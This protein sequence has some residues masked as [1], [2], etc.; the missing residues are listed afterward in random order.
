MRMQSGHWPWEEDTAQ[1]RN[2]F[3]SPIRLRRSATGPTAFKL[4]PSPAAPPLATRS[5][6]LLMA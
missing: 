2:C 4:L 6:R 5:R 3:G 1:L